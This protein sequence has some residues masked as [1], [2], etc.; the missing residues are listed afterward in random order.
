[1]EIL[2][3]QREEEGVAV[4]NGDTNDWAYKVVKD[5]NSLRKIIIS[6]DKGKGRFNDTLD[7]CFS[8]SKSQGDTVTELEAFIEK[9]ANKI[10]T[11]KEGRN[12]CLEE[13][14]KNAETIFYLRKEMNCKQR[15]VDKLLQTLAVCLQ[16]ES[17]IRARLFFSHRTLK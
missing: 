11:H 1:M 12:F 10:A 8:L 6:D 16:Q 2:L 3:E 17:L 15:T 14:I 7:S 13:A 5:L 9:N 4:N